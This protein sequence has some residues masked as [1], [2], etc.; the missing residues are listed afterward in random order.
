MRLV[1]E[2]TRRLV[3]FAVAVAPRGIALLRSSSLRWLLASGSLVLASCSL[4]GLDRFYFPECNASAADR[5]AACAALNMRDGITTATACR[6]WQ[7]NDSGN[8]TFGD[9]DADGDAH[10]ALRC[11]GDDCADGDELAYPG[12]AESCDGADNDCN[13]VV[14]DLTSSI[15]RPLDPAVVLSDTGAIASAAFAAR[16]DG[17]LVSVRRG[18]EIQVAVVDDLDPASGSALEAETTAGPY[19]VGAASDVT[20]PGC[21]AGSASHEFPTPCGAGDTCA[22]SN[23]CV[24]RASDGAHICEPP[25]VPRTST[26]PLSGPACTAQ[27]QCDDGN[28]CNGAETCSPN[29]AITNIDPTNG[30]RGQATDHL[31]RRPCGD[32]AFCF[33]AEHA[34]VSHQV[35]P[36]SFR[37]FTAAALGI[38]DEAIAV[39]TTDACT[40]RPGFV[41]LAAASPRLSF[42]GGY[43]FSTVW[44]GIDGG[45]PVATCPAAAVSAVTVTALPP[46]GSRAFATGLVAYRE[47]IDDG[48]SA[49]V[50]VM[51]LW[52]EQSTLGGRP[53]RYVDG[54]DS[55]VP[56]ELGT[57]TSG[58]PHVA[59]FANGA[60]GATSWP[61]RTRAAVWRW[62]RSRRSAPRSAPRRRSR[63]AASRR[64]STGRPRR[65]WRTSRPPLP[66]RSS[67]TA[68]PRR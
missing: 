32:S 62:P 28:F 3:P 14:D 42:I 45:D 22:G 54:S 12:L 61:I 38:G 67:T 58:R 48:S 16:H 65:T 39:A 35:S 30:C 56:L 29:D 2:P 66:T 23:V 13:G 43:Q 53:V 46:E 8:C 1:D 55:G 60:L 7:C 40:V 18:N 19:D 20:A 51:G 17:V 25:V 63:C 50:G 26:P 37:G 52:R 49:H 36:C 41:D 44:R 34:C 64:A 57:P 4:Q 10:V 47:A 24:V 6:L 27:W 59:A 31:P 68:R 9:L 21:A 33:E 5:V 15:D 11:G